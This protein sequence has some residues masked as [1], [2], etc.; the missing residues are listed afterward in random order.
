MSPVRA[1]RSKPIIGLSGGIGAGKSAV[2]EILGSLGA[3]VI[4]S[5]RLSHEV[6]REPD[7][8]ATL[9][10]WWGDS[11]LTVEGVP[12]R[13]AIA[14]IV[15][16]DPAELTKLEG[17]LYP[18]IHDRREVLVDRYDAD[19]AVRAIVLD[20]P[21]LYEAGLEGLCDSVIFV[22]ADW[23]V[24]VKRVGASRGWDEAELR[25]REKLQFP[26]DHKR[27]NADYCVTNHSRIDELRSEVNRVF[28]SIVAPF[29]A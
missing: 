2:A 29:S 1:K 12:D 20:A 17:L 24:R 5:D 22:D 6:M 26:L 16:K 4:D 25:R 18:R 21:K 9:R 8:V 15:F 27:A 11:V 13:R 19:A 3:A 7:V 28:S 23:Q 10:R 14:A